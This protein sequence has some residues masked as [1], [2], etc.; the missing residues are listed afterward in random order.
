M[1]ASVVEQLRAEIRRIEGRPVV[2]ARYLA[3]GRAEVD[4]LLTGGGFKCGA[5]SQLV[6]TRASGKTSVALSAIAQATQ[7]GGVAAY[8]DGGRDLYPPAAEACGIALERMVIV[9]PPSVSLGLWAVEVL[10]SSGAFRVVV[11]QIP[12]LLEVRREVETPLRRVVLATEKCGG[13]VLW[14]TERSLHVPSA[15]RIHLAKTDEG[16]HVH[17]A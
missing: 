7:H 5:I 9:R 1:G 11:V 15:A 16:L 14:L 17:A 3:S 2:S 8:V 4:A 10:V 12:A 6:G 13:T